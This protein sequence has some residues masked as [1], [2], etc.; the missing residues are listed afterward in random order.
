MYMFCV[1]TTNMEPGNFTTF[2]NTKSHLD[3]GGLFWLVG[4]RHVAVL[5]F[6][7]ERYLGNLTK[8]SKRC[9]K[10]CFYSCSQK[11][12]NLTNKTN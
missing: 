9:A 4:C 7:I 12:K 8:T 3:V 6:P 2:Y 10:R 11:R 5:S 1:T